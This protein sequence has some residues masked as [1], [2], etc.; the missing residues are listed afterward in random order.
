MSNP[1]PDTIEGFPS[2]NP[3]ARLY[4]CR[5]KGRSDILYVVES[6]YVYER[7]LKK[8]RTYTRYLG[9]V[10]NG[11]YYT[12]EEYKKTFTR[13]GKIRAVPK[14]ATLPKSR[15]RPTVH[16]KEK[17]LIDRALIKGLP[18]DLFLQFMQRGSHL[19]VIKR[20]YYIQD[21]RRR[22]KRTYIGQVK[23]NRFYT[24]EEYRQK[25]TKNHRVLTRLKNQEKL[26]E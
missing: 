22:E 13:N 24:M 2:D 4:L 7:K 17:S 3:R 1:T 20:E 8:T 11:V 9:R 15:A 26:H 23:N 10:V 6:S 21:G 12:L 16:R 19:Y 5:R 25:F 14:D 18:D